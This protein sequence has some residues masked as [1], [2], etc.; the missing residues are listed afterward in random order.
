MYKIYIAICLLLLSLVYSCA[1]VSQVQDAGYSPRGLKQYQVYC[2]GDGH[3]NFQGCVKAAGETCGSAG[4]R[5][6]YINRENIED[7]RR[8]EALTFSC[9][10]DNQLVQSIHSNLPKC[11][12][13]FGQ[14]FS[15]WNNCFG[16]KVYSNKNIYEGEFKNAK[17]DGMGKIIIYAK[18][19]S[20]KNEIRSE[21]IAT[22]VGQFKNGRINGHGKW[23]D[24]VGNS[25]EGDFEDNILIKKN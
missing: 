15:K 18:G 12:Q 9:R 16:K 11:S 20:N 23:T 3:D 21:S 22:Y 24:A 19:L 1:G 8:K 25:Y 10:S 4:W 6:V 13:L 7:Y 17:R 5:P 14:D 2:P